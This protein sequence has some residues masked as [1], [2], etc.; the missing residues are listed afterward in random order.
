MK[1]VFL[2][3]IKIGFFFIEALL[4]S[5]LSL[6]I[7]IDVIS[8]VILIPLEILISAA[9]IFT[10]IFF[11]RAIVISFDRVRCIGLFSSRYN[12][13]IKK[14][15]TL[16]ITKMPYKVLKVEIYGYNNDGDEGYAWLRNDIPTVINLFRAKTSGGTNSII[17]VLRYFEV[18]EDVI[19]TLITEKEFVADH[20][21][22]VASTEIENDCKLY[23]IFFKE[24][25]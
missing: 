11:F 21:K 23:K 22:L 18:E 19:N 14:D 15:R 17:K 1:K 25:L 16:V 20:E 6:V 5:L 13:F 4:I 9:I 8:S 12:A 7:Y 24:T 2:F 3:S 10:V